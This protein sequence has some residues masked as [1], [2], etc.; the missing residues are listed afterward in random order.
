MLDCDE[1]KIR[2]ILYKK[3]TKTANALYYFCTN[4]STVNMFAVKYK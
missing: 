3:N 4:T 1:V 2:Q